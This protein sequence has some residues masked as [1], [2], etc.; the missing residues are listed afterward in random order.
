MKYIVLP[1]VMFLTACSTSAIETNSLDTALCRGLAVP[2]DRFADSLLK[3]GNQTPKDV[4]L[5]G[6]FLVQVIDAGCGK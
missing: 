5:D 3:N 1:L 4:V 6:S 2:T